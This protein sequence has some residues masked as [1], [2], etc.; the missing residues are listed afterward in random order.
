ML[1]KQ[2]RHQK[3]KMHIR[4]SIV[5]TAQMPRLVV[6]RSNQHIYAQ[7]IDDVAHRTLVAVNDAGAKGT[8][9][10]KAAQVG[11]E[12]AKKAIKSNIEKVVFDRSGYKFHGRVKSLAESAK[13]AGLKF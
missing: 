12:I 4:K 6:S 10:E 5:G 9:T 8:P 2:V 13:E 7:I 11:A 3:R 1:S